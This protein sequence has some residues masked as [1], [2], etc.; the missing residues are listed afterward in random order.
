MKPV[1]DLLLSLFLSDLWRVRPRPGCSSVAT[2]SSSPEELQNP[3][4]WFMVRALLNKASGTIPIRCA[5]LNNKSTIC[6]K[7]FKVFSPFFSLLED[8][9]VRLGAKI[10]AKFDKVILDSN[11]WLAISDINCTKYFNTLKCSSGNSKQH[12]ARAGIQSLVLFNAIHF[13]NAGQNLLVSKG[14]G[15][16]RK[17]CF[18]NAAISCGWTNSQEQQVPSFSRSS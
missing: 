3:P 2:S 16:S 18:T 12:K 15:S 8:D 7:S 9:A 5:F 17:N 10:M 11:E 1:I 4:S 13:K 14:S 6:V